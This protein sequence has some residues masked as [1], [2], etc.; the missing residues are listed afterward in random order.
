MDC[1]KDMNADGE[2]LIT[3]GHNSKISSYVGA[4]GKGRVGPNGKGR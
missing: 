4:H 3:V 2:E 1:V